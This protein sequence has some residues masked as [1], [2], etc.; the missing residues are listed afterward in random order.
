VGSYEQP[1]TAVKTSHELIIFSL[2][3][4]IMHLMYCKQSESLCLKT[5]FEAYYRE[6]IRK[7]QNLKHL[8]H[9]P[10]SR[11]AWIKSKQ[12][13]LLVFLIGKATEHEPIVVGSNCIC[14]SQKP[15]IRSKLFIPM[16]FRNHVHENSMYIFTEP[17]S[18]LFVCFLPVFSSFRVR[19][20]L[21][22]F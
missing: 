5:H 9:Y 4:C 19:V 18:C 10:F 17:L 2:P 20:Y 16:L 11:K 13:P 7:I 15:L 12:I 8:L 3:I 14:Q 6:T 21:S 22:T 1:L